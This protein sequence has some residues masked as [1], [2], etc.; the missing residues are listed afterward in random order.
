MMVDLTERKI[1]IILLCMVTS[2]ANNPE[3]LK[4]V[5]EIKTD[6]IAAKKIS[7]FGVKVV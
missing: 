4:E 7:N 2:K 5:Q 1:N 6:L 3:F